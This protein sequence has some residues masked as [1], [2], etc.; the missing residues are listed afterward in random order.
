MGQ[1]DKFNILGI[2]VGKEN[3]AIAI[4]NVPE[5]IFSGQVQKGLRKRYLKGDRSKKYY[6]EILDYLSECKVQTLR[7]LCLIDCF[8]YACNVKTKGGKGPKCGKRAKIYY[9]RMD[10][11]VCLTHDNIKDIDKID[12]AD[13]A[14]NMKCYICPNGKNKAIY[15]RTVGESEVPVGICGVHYKSEC[16]KHGCENLT[17]LLDGKTQSHMALNCRVIEVFDDLQSEGIFNNIKLSL[18]ENQ[19]KKFS[20]KFDKNTGASDPVIR[21]IGQMIFSYFCHYYKSGINNC[22]QFEVKRISAGGK[23]TMAELLHYN[24]ADKNGKLN[25]ADVH[26]LNKVDGI[27]LARQYIIRCH[28]EISNDFESGKKLDDKADAYLEVLWYIYRNYLHIY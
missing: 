22:D 13:K 25:Q 1:S 19:A 3:P 10:R 15:Y 20:G 5:N 24:L 18:I 8:D 7:K 2:D 27:E 17:K 23:L 16:R 6:E 9:P 4:I 14:R 28:P 21:D 11:F 26:D 12:L